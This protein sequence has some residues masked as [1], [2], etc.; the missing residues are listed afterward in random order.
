[1]QNGILCD[2]F[3]TNAGT[4][5]PQIAAKLPPIPLADNFEDAAIFR[6]SSMSLH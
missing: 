5:R 4:S 6:F 1:M 3:I 2:T